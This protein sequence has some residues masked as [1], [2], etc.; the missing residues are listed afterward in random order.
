MWLILYLMSN[1]F[2]KHIKIKKN[3]I[4]NSPLLFKYHGPLIP[5]SQDEE[6]PHSVPHVP[7]IQVPPGVMILHILVLW[8]SHGK[9]L[10]EMNCSRRSLHISSPMLL[11]LYFL[12]SFNLLSWN[13]NSYFIENWGHN[14]CKAFTLCIQYKRYFTDFC[15]ISSQL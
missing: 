2:N 5:K 11:Y 12:C 13:N 3:K 6:D 10:G 7:Q 9:K 4:N 14:W 15:F 8:L 1:H